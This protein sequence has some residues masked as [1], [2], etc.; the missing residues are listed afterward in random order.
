[1]P[2]LSLAPS[3]PPPPLPQGPT[4]LAATM[5]ERQRAERE[6]REKEAVEKAAEAAE[7]ER[8]AAAERE[9]DVAGLQDKAARAMTAIDALRRENEFLTSSIRQVRVFPSNSFYLCS[10]H[11]KYSVFE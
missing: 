10:F 1:M 2:P 9:R 11:Q 8:V 5:E 7:R 3:H 6:A 4:D